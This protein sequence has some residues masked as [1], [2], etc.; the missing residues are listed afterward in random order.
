MMQEVQLIEDQ[1]EAG[2]VVADIDAVHLPGAA[3]RGARERNAMRGAGHRSDPA[4]EPGHRRRQRPPLGL[5]RRMARSQQVGKLCAIGIRQ[6]DLVAELAAKAMAHH[7]ELRR[8]KRKPKP[9]IDCRNDL[10]R[11]TRDRRR[12]DQQQ[13]GRKPNLDRNGRA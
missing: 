12:G 10:V 5:R 9:G 4:I 13:Q 2:V 8:R 7:N 1:E 3:A 11:G 6:R